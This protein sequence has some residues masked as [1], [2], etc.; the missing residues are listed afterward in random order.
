M[1]K[2]TTN[3]EAAAH[4]ERRTAGAGH[5]AQFRTGPGSAVDDATAAASTLQRYQQLASEVPGAMQLK[6]RAQLMSASTSATSM[7][8]LQSHMTAPVQRASD[9]ELAQAKAAPVQRAEWPNHTGLPDQLKSG[10]ESLSGMSM[11]H[12]QVHYNSDKPAQLQA[13]AYAQGSQIHVGPGQEQHLPHEAWHV[14]QQAQGRVRPTVQMKGNVPVNDDAGLESEADVMGGRAVAQGAALGTGSKRQDASTAS[15]QVN[16]GS[17]LDTGTV[18]M[19]GHAED[20]CFVGKWLVK[21]ADSAEIAQYQHGEVPAT[22]PVF[23]GPF[24]TAPEALKFLNDAGET[25][26]SDK[27]AKINLMAATMLSGGKGFMMLQNATTGMTSPEMRDLKMGTH[28]VSGTDQERHGVSGIAKVFKVLRHDV[29]DEISGSS[30]RGYRDEDRW[31]LSKTGENTDRLQWMLNRASEAALDM[32]FNDLGRFKGWLGTTQ[33]VYVG[34]SLLVVAGD[35]Q[36]KAVAIDFEHPI[37]DS[38]ESFKM[39]QEGLV[40]GVNNLLDLVH[41]F[42]S[43][44]DARAEREVAERRVRAEADRQRRTASILATGGRI[45]NRDEGNSGIGNDDL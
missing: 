12:V 33:V 45:N 9:E 40:T 37:R 20:L 30:K 29:M 5:P 4:A 2:H 39:H 7:R 19:A 42:K 31:Q 32:I 14:V 6:Q 24:Y 26:A 8:A 10:I 22:A 1:K 18:Q 44:F 34:M 35:D 25:V 16:A 36:G 11:D 27:L 38:D 28:T 13:H 15:S 21:R 3:E 23:H 41:Y 43:T 17:K